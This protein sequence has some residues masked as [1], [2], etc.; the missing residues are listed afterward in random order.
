MNIE[1][2]AIIASFGGGVL[3]SVW[4]PIISF[5]FTGLLAVAGSVAGSGEVVGMAFG[6][7]FG[8]HV[9][10]SGAVAALAFARKAKI[11][12]E[13]AS[14]LTPLA[15]LGNPTVLI[16]GGVFGV[17]GY[18]LQAAIG[19][20]AASLQLGSFDSIA[21]TVVLSNSVVRLAFGNTGLMGKNSSA[22]KFFPAGNELLVD[23]VMGISLGAVAGYTAK[24]TNMG[25]L[26][27]A[28]SAASLLFLELGQPVPGTHHTT[29]CAAVATLASGGNILMGI[30]FGLIAAVLGNVFGRLINSDVDTHI[31]PPACTITV[32]TLLI[33]LLFRA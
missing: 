32:C 25:A 19:A 33:S 3:A 12:P 18:F 10:F 14:V 21:L 16:V 20:G 13:S 7:L 30:A 2:F 5:V 23:V 4:G 28:L 15:S 26:P 6:P 27:F 22:R 1:L 9:A 8:P 17:I 31:D 29:N 24:V 11:A